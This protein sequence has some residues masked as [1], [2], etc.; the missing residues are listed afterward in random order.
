M[1][2]HIS[3]FLYARISPQ[4]CRPQFQTRLK[5][6]PSAIAGQNVNVV[7]NS[8]NDI[9][10]LIKQEVGT[11]TSSPINPILA[12][13]ITV[14]FAWLMLQDPFEEKPMEDPAAFMIDSP[15]HPNLRGIYGRQRKYANGKLVYMR[16]EGRVE[17]AP[18]KK[19]VRQG[20]LCL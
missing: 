11:L 19:N 2:D 4:V 1:R 5:M 6:P 14:L 8:Q 3:V 9:D 18:K 12:S 16:H 10:D 15:T 13:L 20:F 17:A 7:I